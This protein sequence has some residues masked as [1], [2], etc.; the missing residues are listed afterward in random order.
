ML[1]LTELELINLQL[2]CAA[3]IDKFK[4]LGPFFE[5]QVRDLQLLQLK[6]Q[7]AQNSNNHN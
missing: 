5:K 6:L 7:E 1:E 4:S 3:A 2:A